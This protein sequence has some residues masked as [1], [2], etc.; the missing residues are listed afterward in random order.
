MY[1]RELAGGGLSTVDFRRQVD[2]RRLSGSVSARRLRGA[3][4]LSVLG[5]ESC[6]RVAATADTFVYAREGFSV[7]R[8]AEGR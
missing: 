8:G 4:V 7:K 6:H 2:N 1:P 3:L 5:K